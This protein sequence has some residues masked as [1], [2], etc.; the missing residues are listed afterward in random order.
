MDPSGIARALHRRAARLRPRLAVAIAASALLA[1]AG[2]QAATTTFGS[3]LTAAASLNTTNNVPPMNHSGSDTSLWNVALGNG[4]NPAAPTAGQILQVKLKGCAEQA[5]G[6]PAPDRNIHIITLRPQEDGSFKVMYSAT[7]LQGHAFQIPICQGSSDVNTVSTYT[8]ENLCVATGDYVAFN[9]EGGF[10]SPIMYP[11]G[12]P[13][14]VIGSVPG[15]TMDSFIRNEGENIG[16]TFSPNDKTATDGFGQSANE[17]LMLQS[18]LGSGSDA[19]GLC[20]GGGSQGNGPTTS[21]S[22]GPSITP[23]ALAVVVARQ[24]D[25]ISRRGVVTVRV[26]CTAATQCNGRLILKKRNAGKRLG[27]KRFS[28]PAQGTKKVRVHVGRRVLKLV[29]R[30][31]RRL[32]VDATVV[33]KPS[34]AA[35]SSTRTVVLTARRR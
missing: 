17:E 15:S 11:N 18:T 23:P 2:A 10:V 22:S 32:R 27:S 16:S 30:H 4:S 7:D 6:D 25:A 28:I 19:S 31:H 34:T 20:P 33:V 12:V 13:Y 14:R 9:D 35:N 29:R 8:P 5:A 21:V 3:D 1:P 26:R 24:R